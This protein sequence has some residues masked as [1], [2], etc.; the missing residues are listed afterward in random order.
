MVRFDRSIDNIDLL[1]ENIIEETK[2]EKIKAVKNQNFEKAA[3][4]RE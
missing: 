1:V 3:S 2:K 4:F